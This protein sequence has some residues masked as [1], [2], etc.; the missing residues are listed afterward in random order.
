LAPGEEYLEAAVREV[1]RGAWAEVRAADLRLWKVY[2]YESAGNNEF[3]AVFVLAWN[4]SADEVR[5]DDGEVEQVR[6][7]PR[8]EVAERA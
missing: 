6:W 5:F 4:G 7:L 3:Q 8:T 1:L 2:R